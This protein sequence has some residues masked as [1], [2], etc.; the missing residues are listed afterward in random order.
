MNAVLAHVLI[1]IAVLISVTVM[2]SLGKIPSESATLIVM[3]AAGIA[4]PAIG[5]QSQTHAGSS[6]DDKP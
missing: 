3:G 1:T 2:T 5:R 6:P 4:G